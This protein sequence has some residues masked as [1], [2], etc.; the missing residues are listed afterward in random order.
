MLTGKNYIEEIPRLFT[1]YFLV[2]LLLCLDFVKLGTL[3]L[4]KE[5]FS[6]FLMRSE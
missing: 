2:G 3:D 6:V 5:S 4:E 1:F